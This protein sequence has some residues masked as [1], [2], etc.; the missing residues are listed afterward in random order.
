MI[1]RISV[2]QAW[3]S[4]RSAGEWPLVVVCVAVAAAWIDCGRLHM[5]QT[6]D[7]IVP[8]LVS[9]QHWTRFSGAK[10]GSVCWCR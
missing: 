9:I 6:A 4:E 7:S 3:R 1:P 2:A 10:I 8:V 5:L